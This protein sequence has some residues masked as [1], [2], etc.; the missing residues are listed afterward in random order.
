MYFKKETRFWSV[1]TAA[2]FGILAC[3]ISVEG[4]TGDLALSRAL[5]QVKIFPGLTDADRNMLKPAASLRRMKSGEYLTK[6]GD[7]IDKMF[8]V[9]DGSADVLTD[10]KPVTTLSGQF[11]IGETEFLRNRP[12]FVDVIIL[13]ETDIIELNNATLAKI[14]DKRPRLGF[15]LMREIAGIE[16]QRLHDTTTAGSPQAAD[17]EKAAIDKVRLGF[18]AAYNESSASGIAGLLMYDAV[19]M[20]PGEPSVVGRNSIKAR[21][22]KFFSHVSSTFELKTGNIQLLGNWAFL[23]GDWS[24]VDKPSGGGQNRNISGHYLM[25]LRKQ[26]DGAWRIVRDIWNQ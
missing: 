18:N 7:V 17:R 1:F 10:G 14:M 15:I 11:L 19:W 2:V 21:Y 5:S 3:C 13:R 24:R 6:Q 9:L 4:K 8:I 25:I 23:S 22:E 26:P 16:A 20:P 12:L